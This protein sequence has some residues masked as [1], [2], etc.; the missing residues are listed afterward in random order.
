MAISRAC[1]CLCVI[2][3]ISTTSLARHQC[4]EARAREV[5]A[6]RANPD[7]RHGLGSGLRVQPVTAWQNPVA[8][9]AVS[10]ASFDVQQLF[11]LCH[12]ISFR[13]RVNSCVIVEDSLKPR[14]DGWKK[15]LQSRYI[16]GMKVE[17]VSR[18]LQLEVR[19]FDEV[20][21]AVSR[22]WR[23]QRWNKSLLAAPWI[24]TGGPLEPAE[25]AVYD[26]EYAHGL[27][28]DIL[29]RLTE[30]DLTSG[31]RQAA[32]VARQLAYEFGPLLEE[33]NR[34][35]FGEP[36]SAWIL[37]GKFIDLVVRIKSA[38]LEAVKWRAYPHLEDLRGCLD[39][40]V[41]LVR[42]ERNPFA[43][44]PNLYDME[45]YLYGHHRFLVAEDDVV[46]I[47]GRSVL[48]RCTETL[49]RSWL[50]GG[51]DAV[52]G[53]RSSLVD[54]MD[55][56]ISFHFTAESFRAALGT[57]LAL[58]IASRIDIENLEIVPHRSCANPTCGKLFV[59]TRRD[60]KYPYRECKTYRTR[61]QPCP[62]GRS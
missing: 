21:D 35:W 2:A 33:P 18:L 26:P 38:Y 5:Q 44:V 24:F 34:T 31:G 13:C 62:R 54:V 23:K 55:D 40:W 17:Y 3:S 4:V 41:K 56:G 27:P 47:A 30:R 12:T 19:V 6:P 60:Q 49:V 16:G 15:R 9:A 22:Y 29:V 52:I 7:D 11:L 37:L 51:P 25:R 61:N 57:Q 50:Y 48:S 58:A 28:S 42:D 46:I 8:F 53:S 45:R 43:I 1:A 10:P 14:V 59:V 39:E 32:Q 20:P 36:V